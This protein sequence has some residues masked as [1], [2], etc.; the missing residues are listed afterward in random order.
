ME[1]KKYKN[2]YSIIQGKLFATLD[3]SAILLLLFLFRKISCTQIPAANCSRKV[4]FFIVGAGKQRQYM[5]NPLDQTEK[6]LLMQR[7]QWCLDFNP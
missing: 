1:E 4:Y 3:L 5:C 6:I 2:T 7:I